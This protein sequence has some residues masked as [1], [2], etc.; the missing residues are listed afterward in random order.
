M[1]KSTKEKIDYRIVLTASLILLLAWLAWPMIYSYLDLSFVSPEDYLFYNYILKFIPAILSFITG[2]ALVLIYKKK[3]SLHALTVG[4][5]VLL[6]LLVFESGILTDSLIVRRYDIT[7]LVIQ[8][9]ILPVAAYI[10]A[11]LAMKIKN[12][13]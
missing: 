9:L 6:A 2:I 13:D 12:L 7:W 11:Y 3:M 1:K 10:G 8:V 5:A 4:F